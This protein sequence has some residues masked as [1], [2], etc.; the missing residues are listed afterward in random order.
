MA[1]PGMTPKEAAEALYAILPKALLPHHLEDYGIGATDGQARVITRE[2]LSVNLFW[3]YSAIEAHIPREYRA[4]L[5]GYLLGLIHEAW[6]EGFQQRASSWEEFLPEMEERRR[7]YAGI[8]EDRPSPL[9]VARRMGEILEE[10][11]ALRPQDQPQLLAL[12]TDLVP[13]EQYGALLQEA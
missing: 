10:Q 3:I 5:F 4:V 13:V 8:M 7:E 6:Q 11:E 9:A 1:P 2:V 12:L